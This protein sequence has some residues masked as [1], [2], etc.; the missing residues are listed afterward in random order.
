M[1]IVQMQKKSKKLKETKYKEMFEK[2]KEKITSKN[3]LPFL[4]F[5][6]ILINYIPLIQ[7]NIETKKSFAVEIKPMVIAMAIEC[8]ILVLYYIKKIKI[9]KE[10]IINLIL[11][12]VVTIAS[13]TIQVIAYQNNDY[14]ILDFANIACKFVNV[15]LLFV[16]IFSLKIEEK[17]LNTFM[18]C[19]VLMGIAACIQNMILY[20]NDIL[21]H[22]KLVESEA[23]GYAV[24][25]FFA[26]KNQFALYLFS[27]IV[28]I[29]FLFQK[30]SK[31]WYKIFLSL[32]FVLFWYNLVLTFSRTGTAVALIFLAL[33]FLF[34]NKIK[35]RYKIIIGIL[36]VVCL[37]FGVNKLN[38]YNPELLNRILRLNTVKTFTGRTKFWDLAE[39]ELL[40]NTTNSVFGIG[41]FKA[42]RLIEKYNVTQFHNTYVEFLVSG[43]IIELAYFAILYLI[44][45]IKLLRSKIGW[46]YKSIYLSMF[47]SYAIY[48]YFESLGRFSIGCSDTL[49]LIFFVTIPLLHANCIPEE[50]ED[51]KKDK[52]KKQRGKRYKDTLEKEVKLEND[53]EKVEADN[54]ENV[55][56][57]EEI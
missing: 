14:E 18:N 24:K 34:T 57:V 1:L 19:I 5:L 2:L 52:E 53:V 12:L 43:G 17:Y 42:E 56:K 33:W 23:K 45:I 51:S 48:M 55:E 6:I 31:V 8:V 49:C 9:T 54:L 3:L 40:L 16:L 30:K 28:A 27:A 15:L 29:V 10:V 11:L 41:R 35:F 26:H 38:E 13:T 47:L 46:K 25:S 7:V 22:L 50:N 4:L 20:W 21:I 37:Y 39:E 44:I 36:G 32:A